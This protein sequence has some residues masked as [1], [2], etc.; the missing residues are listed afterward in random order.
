MRRAQSIV[1]ALLTA[2]IA[3]TALVAQNGS[4]LGEHDWPLYGNLG[5]H[6]RTVTTS[7]DTAQLYFN[8][9]LQFMYAFG[10][11][12][13]LR[14]FQ[15]AQQSDPKCAMCFWGEAWAHGP[16]LNG[17][18]SLESE[19]K[20]YAAIQRAREL[21]EYANERERAVIEAFA[22]RY[23]QEPTEEMRRP[24]DTLYSDAMAK[25]VTRYS[26]DLDIA[27]LY[28]ESLMLMRPRRGSVDLHDPS[29]RAILPVL[30]GVL[31]RD[32]K[33]PGACHL[34]IH[35]VE[36]SPEPQRAEACSDHLGD[37]IPGASHIRH[38]PSHIYLNIGRYGDAVRSNQNAWHVDQQAAYGGPPGIY[39]SH[40]LHMLLYAAT[41]D[42][43]SAV[44]IQAARDLVK[45]SESHSF[46]P[47]VVLATFGRWDEVL[48]MDDAPDDR[49][50]RGMWL[51]ARG[52]AHLRTGDADAASHDLDELRKII[53]NL[54]ESETFRRH[55]QPVLLG[56]PA[57]LLAGEMAAADGR[58]DE[59]VT[60]L[61]EA[62][63][64]EDDLEYDEPEPWHLPVRH[65]LGAV[66]LESH[67]A[68]E[69]E[70]VYR[71]SLD[72]LSNDGWA[73]FGLE[74]ALLAQGKNADAV[75]QEYERAWQR[76]DVW[77]RSSRF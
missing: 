51:Y 22:V 32:I 26:D 33:H 6:S 43:Q 30:E 65:A 47:P 75:R 12:S 73:L 20:G 18:M 70:T 57:G 72:H 63:Q 10:P 54:P 13:A 59:A 14:S 9:G 5:P 69:A 56:V 60:I 4:S 23:G 24:L 11:S 48:E 76:A 49:F 7:S 36:A 8:E 44:A 41:L 45:V 46:Y 42:G 68:S 16:Y 53:T 50:R 62:A 28:G 74:Q 21:G 1:F 27:T 77:L 66:L 52:M 25:L 37:A 31:A 2:S 67:R 58:L 55:P 38:M 64:I 19:K 61:R 15:A 29:V 17:R 40:N 39:P 34:Y 71:E 3:S 35:L